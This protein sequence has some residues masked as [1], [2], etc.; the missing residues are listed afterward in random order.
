MVYIYIR[1]GVVF[2]LLVPVA[3]ARHITSPPAKRLRRTRVAAPAFAA[4]F[5]AGV[6]EA[7]FL[8]GLHAA[9]DRPVVLGL[10]APGLE[11]KQAFGCVDVAATK[12]KRS[13]SRVKGTPFFF[14]GT[15]WRSCASVP[16]T[17]DLGPVPVQARNKFQDARRS[18]PGCDGGG[19]DHQGRLVSTETHIYD[20][21]SSNT[22][23]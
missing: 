16:V 17:G 5:E 9:M 8:A 20:F 12:S 1:R 22:L 7:V 6:G 18:R 3:R 2:L 15:R 10:F 14:L 11:G 21:G 23:V 19:P 13:V 4:E